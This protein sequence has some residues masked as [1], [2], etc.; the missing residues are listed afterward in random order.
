MPEL[1]LAGGHFA[2]LRREGLLY[3]ANGVGDFALYCNSLALQRP[4]RVGVVNRCLDRDSLCRVSNEVCKV[5]FGNEASLGVDARSFGLGL[6]FSSEHARERG[7]R[8]WGYVAGG[9][10]RWQRVTCFGRQGCCNG[11][12]LRGSSEH[13][14]YVQRVLLLGRR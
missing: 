7:R 4:G 9:G 14:C 13:R 10:R 2:E 1:L 5:S 12:L 3:S 8:R 6:A 11:V